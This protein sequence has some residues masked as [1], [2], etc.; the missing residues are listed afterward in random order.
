[1]AAEFVY[2]WE[3]RVLEERLPEFLA[4]YGPEGEWARLFRRDPAWL[5]TE[6]LRDESDPTRFLT[7]DRWRSR[8]DR[9]AFRQRHAAEFEELDRRCE[10]LTS[11]EVPIGEFGNFAGAR[12]RERA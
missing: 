4:A 2:V 5:G 3:F 12:G 7:V 9:D 8:A 11:F 10:V 1:M 6:L